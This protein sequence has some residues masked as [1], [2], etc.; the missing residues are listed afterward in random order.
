MSVGRCR[1]GL[2]ETGT[3]K[4]SG[5]ALFGSAERICMV[6]GWDSSDLSLWS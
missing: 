5:D 6:Q 1:E 4:G 3:L 2:F